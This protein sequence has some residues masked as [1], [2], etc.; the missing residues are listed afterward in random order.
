MKNVV[1][2]GLL[3]ISGFLIVAGDLRLMLIGVF[4]G[5][6]A[7]DIQSGWNASLITGSLLEMDKDFGVLESRLLEQI[8]LRFDQIE[9]RLADLSRP[10]EF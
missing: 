8:N 6:V 7:L 2:F 3:A 9:Q 10:D 1:L 5:L 4:V